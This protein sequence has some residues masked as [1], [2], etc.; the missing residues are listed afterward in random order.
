M[1]RAP[2]FTVRPGRPA[3]AGAWPLPAAGHEDVPGPTARMGRV[4]PA[5]PADA[6]M[7]AGT[8]YRGDCLAR[9]A[10]GGLPPPQRPIQP[11]R[12][13]STSTTATPTP[14]TRPTTTRLA[15]CE[16][17]R[18][19]AGHL[20]GA[21][22][23]GLRQLWR[24]YR[25]CRKGKRQARDTQAYEA[26]LLDRLVQS[27]DAI[28][29]AC[30]RPSRTSAF[31]VT[32][33]KL[34]QIHAAPF[35]DRVVH[36]ALVERLAPLYERVF[37]HDSY[38]NRLGKGTHAAVDRLQQFMRS[39]SHGGARRAHALQLDVA[40]FF[41]SIHRPTLWR[42]LQHRLA[43]AVR[44]GQVPAEEARTLQSLCR[45]LLAANPAEGARLR[46]NPR[47]LAQVPPHKR[48][49]GMGPHTGLPIGNLTSQFFANVYLNELDQFIKHTLKCRHCVRYVDDFVLLYQDPA[50]LVAWRGQIEAFLAQRLSLRLKALA[51]PHPLQAGTD[52]LGYVVRP[53]YR[54]V[55]RRVVRHLL[56][57]LAG[58]ARRHV[59]PHALH[60]PPQACALLRARLASYLA[61]LRHAG[62]LW[63][64]R[65]IQERHPWLARVF[66]PMATPQAPRP[67]WA[68]AS[69]SGLGSQWR[70]LARTL[71]GH[72]ALV[73]VGHCWQMRG[74]CP[75]GLPPGRRVQQPGLGACTAWPL[76]A[77]P[78]LR[79]GLR[80]QR[81]AY[82][83]MAQTG[84][85]KSGFKRR[86][87]VACW[88]APTFV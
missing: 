16:A 17:E 54:L 55:R 11:T 15:W 59:R 87:L 58:F 48:L 2:Q 56:A 67:L 71:P 76:A 51:Q 28:A 72:L 64:W 69:V 41:N 79:R 7:A 31:V 36:H 73:Q 1:R 78:N 44:A 42:L 13:T 32:R 63:L 22:P 52:F 40:N 62:G 20:P 26:R 4:P 25:A 6:D 38:A 70:W 9:P 12:G 81:L 50:Q 66:A 23:L 35:A 45:A 65:R 46:G 86:A 84:H 8:K 49:G 21:T 27:R 47:L 77:L 53:H 3:R 43:R 33:P 29:S 5:T 37:I 80:A 83:L 85:F 14:T 24:A 61:H 30:W 68:P 75:P 39:V 60:L 57:H 74:A 18:E 34:R 88:A 19:P 82:A 10:G